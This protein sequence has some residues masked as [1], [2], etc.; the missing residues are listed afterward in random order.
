MLDSTCM[1][2]GHAGCAPERVGERH[3]FETCW[4]VRHCSIRKKSSEAL[5]RSLSLNKYVHSH[6]S[7]RLIVSRQ[8][9][10]EMPLE[11]ATVRRDM[12]SAT[13]YHHYSLFIVCRLVQGQGHAHTGSGHQVCGAELRGPVPA[14][15]DRL[16]LLQDADHCRNKMSVDKLF[17][18]AGRSPRRSL[19][20]LQT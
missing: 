20:N 2:L 5:Q 10:A 6:T 1:D 4:P 16:V 7:Q 14:E 3:I 15:L 17:L 13:A 18:R 19:A 12:W 9:L 11:L 8:D